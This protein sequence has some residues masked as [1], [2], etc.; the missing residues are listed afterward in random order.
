ME[1]I[2]ITRVT[3]GEKKYTRACQT[4]SS[5]RR[6][7]S[8][9]DSHIV[10]YIAFEYIKFIHQSIHHMP[11]KILELVILINYKMFSQVIHKTESK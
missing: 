9:L 10:E 8:N 4:V 2:F 7:K 6:E 3:L 5:L 11:V 1:V